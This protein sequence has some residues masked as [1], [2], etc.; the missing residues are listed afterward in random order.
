MPFDKLRENG[1]DTELIDLYPFVVS[2]LNHSKRFFN[3]SLKV[4]AGE[5]ER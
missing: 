1:G 3:R 4:L 5:E 2:L